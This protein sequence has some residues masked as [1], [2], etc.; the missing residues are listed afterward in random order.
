MASGHVRALHHLLADVVRPDAPG[1]AF[2]K[3]ERALIQQRH[4]PLAM[5]LARAA[6]SALDADAIA[7][8]LGVTVANV[9]GAI[10]AIESSIVSG[11]KCAGVLGQLEQAEVAPRAET[12]VAEDELSE[13]ETDGGEMQPGVDSAEDC[14]RG[15][16][17]S[18]TAPPPQRPA[19]ALFVAAASGATQT[20]IEGGTPQLVEAEAV[21]PPD[22]AA[23]SDADPAGPAD[24]S[25]L[26]PVGDRPSMPARLCKANVLT[27][28]QKQ[29][30]KR[31]EQKKRKKKRKLTAHKKTVAKATNRRRKTGF[32]PVM[33]GSKQTGGLRDCMHDAVLESGAMVGIPQDRAQLYA[34]RPP[35]KTANTSLDEIAPHVPSLSFT[36]ELSEFARAPGGPVLHLMR[37]TDDAVRILTGT[38]HGST[39]EEHAFVHKAGILRGPYL[40]HRGVILDNRKRVPAYLVN[41]QDVSSAEKARAALDSFFHAETRINGVFRVSP[42]PPNHGRAFSSDEDGDGPAANPPSSAQTATAAGLSPPGVQL[43]NMWPDRY[44]LRCCICRALFQ[45]G[46]HNPYG[47]SQYRVRTVRRRGRRYTQR[48]LFKYPS[49]RYGQ[50]GNRCCA[51]CNTL[52]E[53]WRGE[54]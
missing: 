31:T 54:K 35:R 21:N 33:L 37:K 52:V 17:P 22:A 50:R 44:R 6:V 8:E 14:E 38:V 1:H 49:S 28:L 40:P 39:T 51:E 41:D 30:Q 26:S 7:R 10:D 18:D 23:D 3:L 45:G 53:E 48:Y 24:D 16:P 25:A 29:I 12:R 4:Q 5:G 32:V 2:Y 46:G 42:A 47:Y 19:S 20:V 36:D 43:R 27:R 34:N 11:E 13:A 15:A 9:R